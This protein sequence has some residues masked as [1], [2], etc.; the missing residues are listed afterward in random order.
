MTFSIQAS[1]VPLRI[2]KENRKDKLRLHCLKDTA[3]KT[4]ALEDPSRQV[5]FTA[6]DRLMLESIIEFKLSMSEP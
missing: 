5:D 2:I 1:N 3:C 4:R 6:T